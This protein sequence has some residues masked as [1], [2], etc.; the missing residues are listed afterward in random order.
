MVQSVVKAKYKL[1]GSTIS[2]GSRGCWLLSMVCM[3]VYDLVR[4]ARDRRILATRGP[5]FSCRRAL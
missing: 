4:R 1:N 5:G 2:L 3:K